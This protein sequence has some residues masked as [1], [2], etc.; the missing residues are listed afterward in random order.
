M[1]VGA[2]LGLVLLLVILGSCN[3]NTGVSA[4][5]GSPFEKTKSPY[6]KPGLQTISNLVR[7]HKSGALTWNDQNV[8]DE[9]LRDYLRQTSDLQPRPEI[10]LAIE[11]GAPCLISRQVRDAMRAAAVCSRGG[12]C[13]E[14]SKWENPAGRQIN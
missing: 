4:Q 2:K 14:D 13:S 3:G 1:K 9:T 8:T 7:L 6:E 10:V 5:C 12:A 11:P